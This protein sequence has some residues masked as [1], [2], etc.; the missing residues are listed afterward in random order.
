M[1]YLYILSIAEQQHVSLWILLYSVFHHFYCSLYPYCSLNTFVL[2]VNIPFVCPPIVLD[3]DF[4]FLFT[5]GHSHAIVLCRTIALSCISRVDCTLWSH[6]S[7]SL[8]VVPVIIQYN[9]ASVLT[10]H[11]ILFTCIMLTQPFTSPW[12]EY[13]AVHHPQGWLCNWSLDGHSQEGCANYL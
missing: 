6:S 10:S 11:C 7:F 13:H 9:L 12:C 3:L 8:T 1:D 2:I 4:L 5:L